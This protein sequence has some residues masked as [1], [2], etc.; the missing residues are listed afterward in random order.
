[1]EY[2]VPIIVAL[3]GLGGTIAGLI[4]GYRKWIQERRSEQS[5]TFR[6]D[7]Q[8]AYKQLWKRAE[9]LNVDGRIA[10]IPDEELML[11]VSRSKGW[12]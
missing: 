11:A 1:M 10:E 6:A 12:R 9:Q 7:Q 5:K 2:V 8:A 4:F 3:L